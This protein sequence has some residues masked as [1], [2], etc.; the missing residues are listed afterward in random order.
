MTLKTTLLQHVQSA[1]AELAKVGGHMV[2]QGQ[3]ALHM[4]QHTPALR[5]GLRAAASVFPVK[6]LAVMCSRAGAA[7]AIVDG[8]TGGFHALRAMKAGKIDGKQAAIHTTAEAGCGFVTS[9]AGTAGTLAAYMVTGAM[10]PLAIA[11]GMGAS[12]GSRHL[13]RTVVGET[14]PKSKNE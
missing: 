14:L 11:A 2:G 10:G 13:Y 6:D 5:K 9:A 12:M 4:A 8:A 1:N 3:A 7:G